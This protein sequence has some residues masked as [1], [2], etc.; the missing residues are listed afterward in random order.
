MFLST[1]E[2]T[3]IA[4][5]ASAVADAV[6][7]DIRKQ[8][9]QPSEGAAKSSSGS[10]GVKPSGSKW[11]GV[12]SVPPSAHMGGASLRGGMGL[13]DIDNE[14]VFTAGSCEGEVSGISHSQCWEETDTRQSNW[15]RSTCLEDIQSVGSEENLEISSRDYG[16]IS[17]FGPS[18]EENVEVAGMAGGAMHPANS[19]RML[20]P[21]SGSFCSSRPPHR[22]MSNRSDHGAGFGPNYSMGSSRYNQDLFPDVAVSGKLHLDHSRQESVRTVDS[23]HGITPTAAEV[24]L[25]TALK[26]AEGE[27]AELRRQVCVTNQCYPVLIIQIYL[28]TRY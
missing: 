7:D 21:S 2:F 22:P 15:M 28:I 16:S 1:E 25:T 8:K 9:A 11:C 10:V 5:Q 24:E 6:L 26:D 4:Y 23:V 3:D 19:S 18:S 14:S 13:L 17:S 12:S 27:V 20:S